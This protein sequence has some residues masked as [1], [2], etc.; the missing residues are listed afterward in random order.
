MTDP[1]QQLPHL[2]AV[3]VDPSLHGRAPEPG[4]EAI[5]W[6]AL[7]TAW[8]LLRES[9]VRVTL[10]SLR[11]QAAEQGVPFPATD[12][13]LFQEARDSGDPDAPRNHL[14]LGPD[15]REAAAGLEA[16]FRE[17]ATQAMVDAV[18]ALHAVHE[19]DEW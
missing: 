7:D 13:A 19:A 2:I 18:F 4:V 11:N 8:N 3:Q 15:S 14:D 1:A 16:V 12:E 17:L 10:Q 6:A 9:A 5:S